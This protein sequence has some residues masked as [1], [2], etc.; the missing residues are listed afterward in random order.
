M[1]DY[2][3]FKQWLEKSE[4]RAVAPGKMIGYEDAKE[5]LRHFTVSMPYKVLRNLLPY[6]MLRKVFVYCG[7]VAQGLK[8]WF[9]LKF[10]LD[11]YFKFASF[12]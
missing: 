7:K 9:L 1:S 4:S 3:K 6:K 2:F 11:I 10:F 8:L 12:S 5:Q